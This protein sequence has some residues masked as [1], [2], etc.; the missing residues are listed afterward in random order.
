MYRIFRRVSARLHAAAL[1]PALL[2][3]G[4][5][6]P[7]GEGEIVADVRGQVTGP[8]GAPVAGAEV[9]YTLMNVYCTDVV[10]AERAV[11]TGADGRYSFRV[12]EHG[13]SGFHMCVRVHVHPPAGSGLASAQAADRVVV[14]YRRTSPAVDIDVQLPA[15]G[16]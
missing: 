1:L 6:E 4:C 10:A 12:T 8:A 7:L 9:R 5:G 3:A 14:L 16:G 2:L 13:R 15:A 11:T